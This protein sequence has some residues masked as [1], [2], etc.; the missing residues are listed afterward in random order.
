MS[1]S[2]AVLMP[3]LA[4][5]DVPGFALPPDLSQQSTHAP[6]VWARRGLDRILRDA[7][8]FAHCASEGQD[9]I[10]SGEV[11]VLLPGWQTSRLPLHLVSPPERRHAAKVRA[12]SEH[13]ASALVDCSMCN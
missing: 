3:H 4:A 13:L 2:P 6:G 9:L 8:Y 10:D 12:F 1:G 11:Q 7:R 5:S